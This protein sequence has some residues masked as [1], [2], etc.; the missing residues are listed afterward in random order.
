MENHLPALRSKVTNPIDKKQSIVAIVAER[1]LLLGK[2][3]D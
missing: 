1:E 3:K 2:F